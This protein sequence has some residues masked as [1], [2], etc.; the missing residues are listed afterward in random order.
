MY[1]RYEPPH[2]EIVEVVKFGKPV[3]QTEYRYR[4]G[5]FTHTLYGAKLLENIVQA[6]ARIVV[7]NAALRL[8]DRGYKFALQAHDELAFLVPDTDVDNAKEIIHTEMTRRPS[9][10]PDLPLS[11]STEAGKSYGD[12]K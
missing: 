9:W 10:A 7:M 8:A 6:L 11:A 4:Y 3:M 12:A 1:L 2:T 5:K